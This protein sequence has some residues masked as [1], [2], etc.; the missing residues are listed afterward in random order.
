MSFL[1]SQPVDSLMQ[2]AREPAPSTRRSYTAGDPERPLAVPR[3]SWFPAVLGHGG[4]ARTRGTRAAYVPGVCAVREEQ[5]RLLQLYE[6]QGRQR[7]LSGN[8][9]AALVQL[10]QA[11]QTARDRVGPPSPALR[12]LAARAAQAVDDQVLSLAGTQRSG[13]GSG[14]F[15]PEG[16][17][18]PDREYE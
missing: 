13:P 7:V 8:L 6:E 18:H 14:H 3:A 15:E 1:R 11:Y 9:M 17:R 10:N 5:R 16:S 12:F 4:G 2:L